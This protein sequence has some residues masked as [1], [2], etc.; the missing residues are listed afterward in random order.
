MIALAATGFSGPIVR[1]S[2]A[3]YR[4]PELTG[5]GQEEESSPEYLEQYEAWEKADQEADPLKRGAM[6]VEFA[7]KYPKSILLPYIESSYRNALLEC[8]KDERYRQLSILADQWLKHHPGDL[9]ATAYASKA[10]DKLGHTKER[11]QYLQEIYK[12]QP[13]GS[14]AIEIAQA[15]GKDKN[16]AGYLE[17][18]KTAAAYPANEGNFILFYNIVKTYTDEKDYASAAENARLTLKAADLVKDPSE[19]TKGQLHRV[20]NACHHLIAMNFME[21]KKYPQAIQSFEQALR[22]QK[23][24]EGYYYIAQCMRWMDKNKTEDSLPYLAKAEKQGGPI[25]A[26]AKTELE[27][28]YRAMH[29]NT[30]VG[31]EKIYK[32]A[33]ELPF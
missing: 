25:S 28:L 22:V 13:S 3:E 11:V 27:A 12:I 32:K 33:D 8:D 7:E 6:L 31:I 15:C 4:Q 23:Y 2:G 10:A 18:M 19:E 16:R 20:R 29:N 5:Q 14:L 24:G 1:P 17:W 9:E 21:S 26:K 30:L